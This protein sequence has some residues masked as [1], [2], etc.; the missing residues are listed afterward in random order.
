MTRFL[1][2]VT[3]L[4]AAPTVE[5]QSLTSLYDRNNGGGFGG[6][7]YFDV[8]VGNSPLTI[9]GFDTNTVETNP[10]DWSV[11]LTNPGISSFGVQTSPASWTMVATGTGVGMGADNPSPVT[12]DNTFSLMGNTLY[13]MALV[14]GPQAGHDYTSGTGA[15]QN[16]SNADLALEMGS[17]SNDP[18][19]S[20]VFD[21][22]VWNGTVY[23][24]PTQASQRVPEGGSSLLLLGVVLASL[25]FARR[26]QS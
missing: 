17:A 4:L 18:F 20:G 15:N 12:L 25:G 3:T 22:R 11:Y 24:E 7:V 8:S 16:Y 1:A 14:M 2:I 19:S 9:T 6:A 13:G 10:F 5:A 23:Y 26:L 21:P